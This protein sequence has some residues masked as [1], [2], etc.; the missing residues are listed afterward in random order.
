MSCVI[1]AL[2]ED[3]HADAIAFTLNKLNI[4]LIRIDPY[5]A[6]VEIIYES[7]ESGSLRINNKYFRIDEISGIYCRLALESLFVETADPVSTCL[8]YTSDLP[9]KR[10]V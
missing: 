4:D 7:K 2:D 9:T 8:L 1:F 3:V 10:I 6:P 5:N